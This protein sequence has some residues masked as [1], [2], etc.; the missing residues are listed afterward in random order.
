[1]WYSVD[2]PNERWPKVFAPLPTLR[3]SEKPKWYDRFLFCFLVVVVLLLL[4]VLFC[5]LLFLFF[6]FFVFFGFCFSVLFFVVVVVVVVFFFLFFFCCF[7]FFCVC[8]CVCVWVCVCMCVCVFTNSWRKKLTFCCLPAP[9]LKIIKRKII[10]S[11]CDN[12]SAKICCSARVLF[13]LK[14]YTNLT[15]SVIEF[16]FQ[17]EMFSEKILGNKAT[18]HDVNVSRCDF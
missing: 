15:L 16:P 18:H 4:F 11:L 13:T 17:K 9:S 3:D 5:L 7:F 12:F 6:F 8:V 14:E 10:V 1:M 2:H